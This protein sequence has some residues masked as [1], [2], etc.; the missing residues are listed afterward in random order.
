MTTHIAEIRLVNESNG[1][2]INK[3]SS[4]IAQVITSAGTIARVYPANGDKA[5]APNA[6]RQSIP[7]YLKAEDNDGF[8][9][10]HMNQNNIITSDS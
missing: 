6:E 8:N 4:T 9:L 1:R 5:N 2:V 10:V 3:G 7:D